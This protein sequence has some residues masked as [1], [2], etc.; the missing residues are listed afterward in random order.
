MH[1]KMIERMEKAYVDT[2]YINDLHLEELYGSLKEMRHQR[3]KR[4]VNMNAASLVVTCANKL[5]EIALNFGNNIL[6]ESSTVETK[7]SAINKLFVHV[8]P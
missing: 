8:S 2:G 4:K 7:T 1:R 5:F 3:P 6:K